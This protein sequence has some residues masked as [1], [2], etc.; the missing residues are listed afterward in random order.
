MGLE[1]EFK[2]INAVK[3][4]INTIENDI[5][6]NIK[7]KFEDSGIEVKDINI[8]SDLVEFDVFIDKM[9]EK[10]QLKEVENKF[11]DVEFSAITPRMSD[12]YGSIVVVFFN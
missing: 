7:Q 4:E 9:V 2:E 8:Q 3:E 6:E 5:K 1:A 11:D 12:R 10:E